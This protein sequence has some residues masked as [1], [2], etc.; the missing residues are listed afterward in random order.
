[1]TIDMPPSA[2]V[3]VERSDGMVLG[4]TRGSSLWR[5]H[6][7]GGKMEPHESTMREVARR[8]LVEETGVWVEDLALFVPI[9]EFTSGS[10]RRVHAFRCVTTRDLPAVYHRTNEGQPDWVPP[11]LLVAECMPFHKE[12]RRILVAAGVLP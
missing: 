11:S 4:I 6:L 3:L 12:C 1:M 2:V 10:G 8:E 5:W 7:P 9:T